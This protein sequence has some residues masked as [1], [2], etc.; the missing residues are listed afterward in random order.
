LYF[1]YFLVGKSR[2]ERTEHD[3]SNVKIN[4]LE[5]K[6]IDSRIKW[7]EYVVI[8]NKGRIPKTVLSMKL[9]TIA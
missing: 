4:T 5:D 6:L 8:L 2:S 9:G 3:K 1:C 7:C